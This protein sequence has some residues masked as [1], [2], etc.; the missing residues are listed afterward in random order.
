MLALDTEAD[1]EEAQS[2]GAVEGKAGGPGLAG[3]GEEEDGDVVEAV[4]DVGEVGT[5]EKEDVGEVGADEKEDVGDVGAD[6]EEELDAVEAGVSVG[7]DEAGTDE[8]EYEDGFK[9]DG[10]ADEGDADESELVV[11]EGEA[12]PDSREEVGDEGEETSALSQ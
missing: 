4:V 8:N 10:G 6:E 12:A 7:L 5:D 9:E 11:V 3:A 2:D 1:V